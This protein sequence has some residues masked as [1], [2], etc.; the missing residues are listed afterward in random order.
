MINQIHH[1]QTCLN[2]NDF[3]SLDEVVRSGMIAEGA[4]VKRFERS[5]SEYLGMSGGVAT[6]SGTTALLLGLKS[7]GVGAN[8]EVILPTYVCRSV[9]DAVAASG[10]TPVLCDVGEDWCINIETIKTKITEKTKAIIFVHIFGIV[11]DV[12]PLKESGLYIL[13]DCAQSFGAKRKGVN[14]GSMGDICVLS[15]NAT[16]CLATGEG[17]MALST[18][19]ALLEKLRYLKTD[20]NA[21]EFGRI[22]FPLSDL[23]AALG[24]SQLRQYDGFLLKRRKIAE[25]YLT[26][27]D[28]LTCQLP[29]QIRDRSVF[30]RFPIR[31][32]FDFDQLREAFGLKKIQVRRGVD[33][34]LHR[35]FGLNP[36]TF[37]VAEKLFAE[38]ISIPIYPGLSNREQARVIDAC[39]IMLSRNAH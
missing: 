13:E 27:L 5:V 37:P 6:S 22:R 16:K 7:L 1:S 4:I 11:G 29:N 38:T 36:T 8:D 34:L 21:T 19:K 35:T 15:F 23:H 30:F 9:W 25:I 2:E 3:K 17:G 32:K 31:G 33:A 24:I 39:R 26:D 18:D 10:A 20:Q 12:K 14:A 28:G